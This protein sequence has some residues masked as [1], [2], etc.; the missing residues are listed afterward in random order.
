MT[1]VVTR[2]DF[3]KAIRKYMK[4]AETETVI[5]VRNKMADWET[6]CVLISWKQYNELL[7][8]KFK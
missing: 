3:R 5:I 4:M 7:G 8:S 2:H 6:G 1:T